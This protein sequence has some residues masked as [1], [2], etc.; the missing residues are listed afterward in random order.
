MEKCHQNFW[1]MNVYPQ[2]GQ[3]YWLHCLY[4]LGNIIKKEEETM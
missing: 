3:L 4:G 2:M 1:F